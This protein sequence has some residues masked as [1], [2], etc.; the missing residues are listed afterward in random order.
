MRLLITNNYFDDKN[1]ATI[2]FSLPFV[3]ISFKC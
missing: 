2:I 1:V 3:I